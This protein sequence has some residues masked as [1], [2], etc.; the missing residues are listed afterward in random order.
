[1]ASARPERQPPAARAAEP[2]VEQGPRTVPPDVRSS[3]PEPSA[4]VPAQPV[5]PPKVTLQVIVYSEVPS[6]RMV[7]IDGH[8]YAEGDLLD[9]ETVLERI[10]ADGVV[11][12]RRG[13]RF[14]I[15]DRRE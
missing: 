2:R 11:F 4:A 6:Q 10:N 7:F 3:A 1:V 14:V 15:A 9:A 5:E 8:R 13:V 12:K